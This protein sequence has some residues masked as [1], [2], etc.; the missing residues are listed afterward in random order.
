MVDPNPKVSGQG[1]A[2]LLRAGIEVEVGLRQ[3]QAAGLN[4]AFIKF[5]T[6]GIP[7]VVLK[8]AMTLD[9][10][11]ATRTGS[12]RWITGP[13]SRE[14]VHRLRRR[15]D[16]VLVGRGTLEVDDPELTCRLSEGAGRDPV[17]LILDSQGKIPG[18]ARCLRSA[19]TAPTIV[20]VTEKASAA[21]IRRLEEAGAEVLV[22]PEESSPGQ[23]SGRVPWPDLLRALG[24]RG[25]TGVLVEGGSEVHAS[26]LSAGVVDKVVAFLAPKIVGGKAAPGPVGGLGVDDIAAAIPLNPFSASRYG[27]DLMIDLY[28]PRSPVVG[29][30]EKNMPSGSKR[31]S[32]EEA[33][34]VY[35]AG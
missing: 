32:E 19:S 9:G 2:Q 12:S 24:K 10:K 6:A 34:D 15:Y 7:L 1:I 25:I 18:T 29:Y 27:S 5:I 35:G 14:A 22:L 16:A 26:S 3:K 20:V 11:I 17:R 8:W 23:V 21:S 33:S 4:D 31:A 28:N 13:E 30:L